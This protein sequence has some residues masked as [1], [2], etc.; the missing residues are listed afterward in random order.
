VAG[1]LYRVVV[2]WRRDPAADFA[3]GRYSRGH[4]WRFDAGIVVKASASPH[5]VPKPYSVEEAIDPE[6]AFVAAI[7]SC[8]MLSFIDLARRAGFTVD[9]YEDDA[10]GEMTKNAAGRWWLSRVTLRPRIA[11]SGEKVPGEAD[12]DHLHHDAHDVCFISNSV[13]TDVRI[14]PAS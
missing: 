5:V 14:E 3:K 12:L 11:F 2:N 8:H 6:E 13:K 9:S 1:H 4:H 7:A 10:E